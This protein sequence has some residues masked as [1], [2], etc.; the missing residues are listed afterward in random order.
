MAAARPT[1][2]ADKVTGKLNETLEALLKQIP[3]PQTVSTAV[4]QATIDTIHSLVSQVGFTPEVQKLVK[5]VSVNNLEVNGTFNSSVNGDGDGKKVAITA[6]ASGA[7]QPTQ[8]MI[9]AEGF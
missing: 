6:I 3:L 1:G 4:S 9:A 5:N 8:V 7:G 2:V